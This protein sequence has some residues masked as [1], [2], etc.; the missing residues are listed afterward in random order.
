VEVAAKL[1]GAK[2]SALVLMFKMEK[3]KVFKLLE[4]IL[5]LKKLD[6]VLQVALL[7]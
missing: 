5:K 1:K 3:F 6:Y 2:L 7:C 4:E